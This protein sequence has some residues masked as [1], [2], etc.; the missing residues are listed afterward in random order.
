M[1]KSDGHGNICGLLHHRIQFSRHVL[2]LSFIIQ[3]STVTDT[4]MDHSDRWNDDWPTADG[5]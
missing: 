4:I 5:A 1:T 2:K 3:A